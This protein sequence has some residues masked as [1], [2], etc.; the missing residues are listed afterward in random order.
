M[1]TSPQVTSFRVHFTNQRSIYRYISNLSVVERHIREYGV[2]TIRKIIFYFSKNNNYPYS[3]HTITLEN[4]SNN[5]NAQFTVVFFHYYNAHNI[6]IDMRIPQRIFDYVA[7]LNCIKNTGE[8]YRYLG[9]YII[10]PTFTQLPS[11]EF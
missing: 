8:L 5:V 2:N 4:T 7:L 6:L 1:E 10:I 3:I 11:N 9:R